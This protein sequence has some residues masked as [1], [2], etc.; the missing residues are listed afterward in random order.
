MDRCDTVKVKPWGEG[1]GDFVEINVTDFD[2]GTHTPFD[3]L[4][5]DGDGKKGGAKP[6]AKAAK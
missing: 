4:D 1:Q 3:A 6:R 5:H 2:P